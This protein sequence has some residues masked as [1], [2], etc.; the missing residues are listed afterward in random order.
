MWKHY[1]GP[2]VRREQDVR[3]LFVVSPAAAETNWAYLKAEGAMRHSKH[4]ALINSA[5][6]SIFLRC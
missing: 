5:L 1:F 2:H 6:V 4:S 3:V